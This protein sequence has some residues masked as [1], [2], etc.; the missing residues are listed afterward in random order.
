V[1][2]ALLLLGSSAATAATVAGSMAVIFGG[3]GASL[4]G[5]KMMKRTCGLTDFAFQQYGDKVPC[6]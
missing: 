6:F 5:Y 4:A 1:A 2:G 3:T